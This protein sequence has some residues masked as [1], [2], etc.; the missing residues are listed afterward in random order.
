MSTEKYMSKDMG[1][2][3]GLDTLPQDHGTVLVTGGTGLVGSHSVARLLREGHRTRVTVRDTGQEAG[4]L[5]A[6]R[7][8]GVDPAGL[9]EFAVADLGS[10]SGWAKAL[11]GVGHVLHHASPFPVTPP[12]TEDELV[13]PAREGALRVV[14]A[15]REAGVSRVVM[16]SSY[17]AV[18]Y[19]LKSDDHYTETDWTDPDTEGLPAYHKS[20]VLAERAAWEY[21]RTHDDIELTVINPTGI[22]GP[23]LGDRPSG[24]V[25]LVKG[26]LTGQLPVVPVMYFG[27][28][29]VRDVV[30]LHL[31]AMT[32]P[33]AAGE[34]FIAVSGSSVSL[35]GMAGILRRH[36]PAA[37]GLLPATELTVEQVR[38]AAKTD[39]ALRDAAALRGRIPVI[40]NEKAR[41]VLGWRPRDVTETIVATA[42][43]LIRSGLRLPTSPLSEPDRAAG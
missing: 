23:P 18:G 33:K 36:F 10:D 25:G 35:F 1:T 24:S 19:T 26:M 16:T 43:G 30:D 4:V 21:A 7:R 28:V 15:A 9:L 14:A 42:D 6:L 22:F 13:R 41:S 40:S 37:D 20:K 31:R 12:E 8:A 39:P 17:A 27:V 5:T 3:A 29:D 2:E 34:R 11:D 32:H 38:E